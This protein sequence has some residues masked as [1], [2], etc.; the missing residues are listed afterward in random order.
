MVL[1]SEKLTN[2]EAFGGNRDVILKK[3]AR[4]FLNRQK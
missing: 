2:D 1:E 3:D 4:N